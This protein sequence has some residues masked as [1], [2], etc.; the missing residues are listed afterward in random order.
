MFDVKTLKTVTEIKK[1]IRETLERNATVLNNINH[2]N[3]QSFS[4]LFSN[5]K[6]SYFGYETQQFYMLRL[7]PS[8]FLEYLLIFYDIDKEL[9]IKK[10]DARKILSVGC[11]GGI[12][13][14]ALAVSSLSW[15]SYQ[16]IDE[17]LWES[18]NKD[19]KCVNEPAN[20]FTTMRTQKDVSVCE[21]LFDNAFIQSNDAKKML[22]DKNMFLFPRSFEE[23]FCC[24]ASKGKPSPYPGPCKETRKYDYDLLKKLVEQSDLQ[25]DH[26]V[27]SFSMVN[28]DFWKL[29]IVTEILKDLEN[30]MKDRGYD[31]LVEKLVRN[32]QKCFEVIGG[33]TNHDFYPGDCLGNLINACG[34]HKAKN[35]NLK[36]FP[37]LSF[38]SNYAFSV[39]QKTSGSSDDQPSRD[40]QRG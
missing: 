8:Y 38:R 35:P 2:E 23:I 17:I 18:V 13:L 16:G 1:I 33:S 28:L 6:P 32:S 12:D 14:A 15:N 21:G 30:V 34:P 10:A 36:E 26:I 4:G 24:R 40:D 37:L 3:A 22:Q 20:Y 27:F 7:F 39:Y 29:E 31:L 5:K 25:D 9:K 19:S 11:G